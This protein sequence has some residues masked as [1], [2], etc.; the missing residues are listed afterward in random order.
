[1]AFLAMAR[2]FFGAG[3]AGDRYA[4]YGPVIW[5]V[6][7]KGGARRGRGVKSKRFAAPKTGRAPGAIRARWRRFF[8]EPAR[9]DFAGRDSLDGYL[10]R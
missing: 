2:K 10:S 6:A 7:N 1:M 3:E 8:H 4:F 9:I 5:V